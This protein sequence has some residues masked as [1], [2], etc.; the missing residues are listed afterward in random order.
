MNPRSVILLAAT[1]TLLSP[2]GCNKGRKD[3]AEKNIA[4]TE[5]NQPGKQAALPAAKGPALSTGKEKNPE[6]E[7]IEG[8]SGLAPDT[9]A[10]APD[11]PDLSGFSGLDPDSFPEGEE[12]LD[13]I[14]K[15]W[16]EMG[17]DAKKKA[18]LQDK[19]LEGRTLRTTKE[20]SKCL[21]DKVAGWKTAG[22]VAMAEQKQMG[23]LLPMVSRS[24][25]RGEDVKAT[26]TL[27]DTL[28]T[29]EIRVGYEMGLSLTK[30]AKSPRQKLITIDGTEGYILVHQAVPQTGKAS[31]SK[32]ALLVAS[33]FLVVLTVDNLADFEEAFKIL[34]GAK[35]SKIKDLDK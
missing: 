33:R 13:A 24:F 32:G 15:L 26:L 17:D 16:T 19:A 22:K 29:S 9:Q 8:G 1:F 12:G 6:T 27:M 14:V 11:L 21:P 20:L 3:S 2:A 7:A 18:D 5:Q 35:I 10:G 34:S 31:E 23:S 28:K 30:T 25:S 4:K